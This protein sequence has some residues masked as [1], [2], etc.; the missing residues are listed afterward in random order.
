L[1]SIPDRALII[2]FRFSPKTIIVKMGGGHHHP[3][4]FVVPKVA[5]RGFV[6]VWSAAAW[7]FIQYRVY[8]DGGHHFLHHHAWDEPK[9][10]EYL[11]KIDKK[12]PGSRLATQ[13]IHHH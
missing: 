3:G 6:A 9:V 10:I 12:F 13:N 5:G 2:E 4:K 8:H 11:E 1:K 7:F